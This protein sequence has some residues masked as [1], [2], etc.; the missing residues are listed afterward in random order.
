MPQ[1]RGDGAQDR[2]YS[3]HPRHHWRQLSCAILL[4]WTGCAAKQLT[5][6]D[7]PPPFFTRLEASLQINPD[8]HGRSM[9]TVVQ[10][11]QLKD[12]FRM[13]KANFQKLWGAPDK[14]LEQDLLHVAEFTLAPGE[15]LEQW[16]PRDPKARFVVVMGH[17]RDPLG[18]NWRRVEELRPVFAPLCQRQ[19]TGD[20]DKPGPLDTQ[21]R[22]KLYARQ[23][24]RMRTVPQADETRHEP[25]RPG[26]PLPHD[27]RK[28]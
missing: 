22:F 4:A 23:I 26:E 1:D 21:L 20:K 24:E 16:I 19:A 11:L 2:L 7:T 28:R 10:V 8:H 18:Y 14:L 3:N 5:P 17:F 25:P 15:T 27:G 9:P 13:E 6:C 12:S